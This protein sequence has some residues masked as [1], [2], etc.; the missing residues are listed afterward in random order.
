MTNTGPKSHK[1]IILPLA[2]APHD[3]MIVDYIT[4][5]D[6]WM[7]NV[8]W[9]EA[10]NASARFFDVDI[11]NEMGTITVNETPYGRRD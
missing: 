5:G 3:S 9:C 7:W 8:Y 1:Q 10:G 11:T 2:D 6:M 4:W